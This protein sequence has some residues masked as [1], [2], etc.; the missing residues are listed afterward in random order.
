MAGRS[1]VHIEIPAKDR[2][3]LSK[4]Y[5]EMFGWKLQEFPEMNYTT[6]ESGSVGGGFAPVE[7]SQYSTI[8]QVLLHI[9]SEDI[10]AD[11]A[12]IKKMGGQMVVPKT[13]IPGIGWFAI[14][15]D[16]AGNRVALYT[17]L[18]TSG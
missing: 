1:I 17:P 9:G 12:Q 2:A 15:N 13:E 14:F 5:A 11:L 7:G 3:T 18:P 4:F 10:E 6:F 16:P 8:G